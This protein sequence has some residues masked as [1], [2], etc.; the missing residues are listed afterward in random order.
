MSAS[1]WSLW[2]SWGQDLAWVS[3]LHILWWCWWGADLVELSADKCLELSMLPVRPLLQLPSQESGCVAGVVVL[4]K[5][6]K[7]NLC[8]RNCCRALEGDKLLALVASPSPRKASYLTSAES[9]QGSGQLSVGKFSWLFSFLFK[10]LA[11]WSQS[12]YSFRYN[13]ISL[14]DHSFP[15]DD[16]LFSLEKKTTFEFSEGSA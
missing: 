16:L 15:V 11:F 13:R 10:F 1:Q 4:R 9:I 3:C 6:L 14:P 5:R 8:C 12:L 7:K 2:W